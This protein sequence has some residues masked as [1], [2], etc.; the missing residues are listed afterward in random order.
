[1]MS[2]KA[3]A[4]AKAGQQVARK[5]GMPALNVQEGGLGSGYLQ[6]AANDIRRNRSK[7]QAQIDA[8]MK[9]LEQ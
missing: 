4:Q 1:M 8:I 9:D 5:K 3:I 6:K 2:R 7:R